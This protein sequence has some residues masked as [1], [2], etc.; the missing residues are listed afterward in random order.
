MEIC[1]RC[2]E[3]IRLGVRD[4]FYGWWH[5]ED[6]D[7]RPGH[8]LLAEQADWEAIESELHKPR[9]RLDTDGELEIYTTARHD[10]EKL[11]NPEQRRA[12]IAELDA[13][14]GKDAAV[15]L[16]PIEVRCQPLPLDARGRD[17]TAEVAGVDGRPRTATIPGGATQV[18]SLIEKHPAWSVKRFTYARGPYVG[19]KGESLGVSDSIILIAMVDIDGQAAYA[20]FS[21]RDRKADWAWRVNPNRTVDHLGVKALKTWMK[22]CSHG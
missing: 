12:A 6:V 2:G 3:E 15:A 5:R 13:R 14:E 20:V 17:V 21:W 7:H 4:G 16:E 8:G 18:L 1:S 19:T 22:E 9:E 10:A 11:K